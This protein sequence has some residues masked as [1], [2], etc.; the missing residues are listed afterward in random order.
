M[1]RSHPGSRAGAAKWL[2]VVLL[3]VIATCLLIELGSGV[4][5]ARA[6]VSSGQA[7]DVVVVAGK[8]TADSYGLYLVDL[9]NGTISVYQYLASIRKLRLMAA[10]N[11]TFDVQ[12]DDYNTEP[13]PRDI[14]K[15]VQ[16]HK[17]LVGPK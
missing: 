9:R 12:L 10:R 7:G 13:S 15:L 1:R 11:F 6:E 14:Q 2:I 4:S 17:R 5:D 3:S 8:V 16:Q